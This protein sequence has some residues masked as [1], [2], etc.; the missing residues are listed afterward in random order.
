MKVAA[1][2]TA[3][4][5]LDPERNLG[6]VLDLMDQAASQGVELAVFPECAVSGYSAR[7]KDEVTSL[8]QPIDGRII[9]I[10][11]ARAAELGLAV[12]L[13][14]LEACA[15]G[16]FANSAVLI[17]RDGT[18]K[19]VHRKAHIARTGADC[20]TTPGDALAVHEL[21]GVK[22]GVLICY[23]VRFPEAARVLAL[24]GAELLVI[25]ANWPLGAELNPMILSP[26]RAAENALPLVA[27]NRCGSEDAMT[28]LGA[29][30]IIDGGGQVLVSAPTDGP[31]M[32]V[33]DIPPGPG[34]RERHVAG[35]NYVVDLR[36][37]RRTDLYLPILDR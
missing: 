34:L 5:R 32:L 33:H 24:Q 23:E 27:A 11:S 17:D 13:G 29:S 14:H 35:S 37:H 1:I 19:G 15:D 20:F 31:A 21:A 9:R 30:R 8:A 10:V 16:T 3:P 7:T 25:S 6:E 26:A 2:Q 18:V 12:I 36:G 4:A 28:F 22:I